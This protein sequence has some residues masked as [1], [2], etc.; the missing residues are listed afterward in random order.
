MPKKSVVIRYREFVDPVHALDGSTLES[1]IRDALQTKE[2]GVAIGTRWAKRIRRDPDDDSERMV[3]N[4]VRDGQT[5][6]FGNLVAYTVGRDQPVIDESLNAREADIEQLPAPARKQFVN[7][8]MFWMITDN[9]VFVLRHGQLNP[10]ELEAYLRW[11][12]AERTSVCPDN[13]QII[14]SEVVDLQGAG[15]ADEDVTSVK[16]GSDINA[17]TYGE[18]RDQDVTTRERKKAQ[19]EGGKELARKVLDLVVG[20]NDPGRVDRILREVPDGVD[21]SVDVEI[22]FDTRKRS[23]SRSALKKIAMATR[24]LP[25]SDV[26]LVTKSGEISG[27]KIR[28]SYRA[29]IPLIGSLLNRDETLHAMIE[30]YRHFVRSGK[31][32]AS[33]LDL[34]ED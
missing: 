22:G 33:E 8:M 5:Y 21:L 12:L 3:A 25:D 13:T 7:S 4:H 11:L 26:R 14:L 31:I 29:S 9:H 10:P 34:I 15:L 20:N 17:Q 16:I 6:V 19:R 27:K 24:N 30:A 18:G 1:V 28:L 23:V 32:E 2:N